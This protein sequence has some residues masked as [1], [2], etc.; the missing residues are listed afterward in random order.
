MNA[1]KY[2]INEHILP[3]AVIGSFNC[4]DNVFIEPF[5]SHND[6]IYNLQLKVNEAA[7]DILNAADENLKHESEIV[8]KTLYN[9]LIEIQKI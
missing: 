7:C 3:N 6:L 5:I 4:V 1:R 9:L 2:F 8:W